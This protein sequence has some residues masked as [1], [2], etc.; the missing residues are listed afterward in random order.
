MIKKI[1]III[2]AIVVAY[3]IVFFAVRNVIRQEISSIVRDT[4][5]EEFEY[6]RATF[7]FIIE[8]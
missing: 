2:S 5:R 6:D 8:E 1:L 3:I 4:M 7:K